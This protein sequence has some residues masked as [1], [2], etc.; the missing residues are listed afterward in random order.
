MIKENQIVELAS[1]EKYLVVDRINYNEANYLYL[2]K[3]T[4]NEEDFEGVS[5]IV[6]EVINGEQVEVEALSSDDEYEMLKEVFIR[7]LDNQ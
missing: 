5:D 2:T 4:E 1:G 3:V 7:R 6:K